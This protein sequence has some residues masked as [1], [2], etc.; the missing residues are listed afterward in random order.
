[1]SYFYSFTT[2]GFYLESMREEYGSDWSAD[3]VQISRDEYQSLRAGLS[4]G[5]VI[6]LVSGKPVLRPAPPRPR[7]VPQVVSRFQARAALHQSGRLA[8]VEA[9]I[10]ESDVIT[11][12]AWQDA[13]EFRRNSP[14]ILALGEQLDLDLDALFIA[15]AQIQ[16]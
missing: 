8:E 12:M 13:Q 7:P 15:A 16:A 10:A 5:K 3:A 9:A 14:T 2:G 6:A 11:Q 4:E 1:M